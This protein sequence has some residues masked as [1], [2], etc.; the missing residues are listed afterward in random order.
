MQRFTLLSTLCII[1]IFTSSCSQKIIRKNNILKTDPGYHE[2][3]FNDHKNE[4]GIVPDDLIEQW[5]A[6][7]QAIITSERGGNSPIATVD[8][9]GTNDAQGGRTRAILVSAADTNKILAGSVSGGLWRSDDGGQNWSAIN[10]QSANLAVTC[11]VENPFNANEIYYGTGEVRGSSVPAGNGVYKSTDGGLTFERIASTATIGDMKYCNTMAHS[12]LDSSTVWVGTSQG[13]YVSNNNGT[14]WVKRQVGGLSS[15]NISSIICFPDSSMMV[16]IQGSSRIYKSKNIYTNTPFVSITDSTIFPK[17]NIGKVLIANCKS[18]PDI[19]YAFYGSSTYDK[20]ADIGF[21]RTNDAGKTWF[22]PYN[23]TI[24]VGPAYQAYCQM[25]GVH[26]TNP[27][28]VVV[29]AVN[30]AFSK[31]GGKNWQEFQKGHS[32][33][34]VYYHIP[35]SNNFL[36]GND[37][38][39]YKKQWNAIE[40]EIDDLNVGYTTFQYYAGGY[41][42]TGNVCI[43][44]TQDNGTWRYT[45]GIASKVYGGDGAYAHIHQQTPTTAYFATQNGATYRRDNFPTTNGLITITPKTAVAEGVDFI[46]EY[47]INYADGNQLYYRTA[48]GIWRSTNKGTNWEKLNK[49]S[50]SNISAIGITTEKNPVMYLGGINSFYRIDSAST[51]TANSNLKNISSKVPSSI[52]S[53][54]WGTIS[55]HTKKNNTFYV[56]LTSATT[57]PRAWKVDAYSADSITWTN[58][59]GNLPPALS[60]YQVQPHPDQPD[61]VFVAGTAFGLYYT[62]DGGKTWTKDTRIPNVAIFEIKLRAKDKNLFVFTHGRGVWQ[63]TFNDLP[64]IVKTNELPNIAWNIY[65]NPTQQVLNIDCKEPITTTQIFD[66]TGRELMRNKNTSSLD[67]SILKAGTYLLKV[68]NDQG[69]FATKQFIKQ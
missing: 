34:H 49:S 45:S 48:K 4:Q 52:R 9:L 28:Y 67:V 12:P 14:S 56:G 46:N 62:L 40:D 20:Q 41:A 65:P 2:Q 54:V 22:K 53:S 57:Q 60:V 42:P 39:V 55:F 30:C 50:I 32:D 21:F 66:I 3:W 64:K 13:L 31:D 63:L 19:V 38:G 27:D 44:G 47:Q 26:P 36:I 43:G 58:I 8:N 61:S 29:G 37:G 10:D 59:S 25:L 35:N 18:Q 17:A 1:I 7:D 69:Q 11:I 24:M 23:D 33:N 68:F 6:H 16:G 5:Y 15:G 51:I